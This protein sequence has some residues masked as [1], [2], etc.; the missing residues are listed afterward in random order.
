MPGAEVVRRAQQAV[1]DAA[2]C[3]VVL[4]IEIDTDLVKD[5]LVVELWEA[6]PER[7]KLVVLQAQSAQLRRLAYTTDGEQSI[8]YSPH[9]G[10]VAVGAPELVRLPAVLE[11]VVLARRVWIAAA[12]VNQ[13]RVV[14]VERDGG[15]VLYHVEVPSRRREA[16]WFWIDARD[17]LVRR[18]T[19]VDDYLGE[20]TIR[21]RELQRF[22]AL[23]DAA[24]ELNV[25]E[26]V[27][28]VSQP[29]ESEQLFTFREAQTVANYRLRQPTHIPP[30]TRLD[31]GY[32][33]GQDIA[34]VYGGEHPFTL[35]QGPTVRSA[36]ELVGTE[37]VV[38][39]RKAVL[40]RDEASGRL[41]LT[42]S[43]ENLRFSL[44]GALSREELV[45]IAESLE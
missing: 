17:W 9:A 25:P 34:L 14:S 31:Y 24:F 42:W 13:A 23:P 11:P 21:V 32:Q 4:D 39:G 29:I 37:A 38:R 10:Q 45:R 16:V 3:H 30:E 33:I 2:P 43:D 22:A 19:Y 6:P 27:P 7:F 20:G 26:G 36:A 35:V 15:L 18:A 1:D 44:A 12:E 41:V 8:L 5:T 40:T 28:V